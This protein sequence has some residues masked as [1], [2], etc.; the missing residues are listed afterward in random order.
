VFAQ[1]LDGRSLERTYVPLENA[2]AAGRRHAERRDIVFDRDRNTGETT[3][4]F[5]VTDAL[6]KLVGLTGRCFAPSQN[7]IQVRRSSADLTREIE[8]PLDYLARVQRSV[9]NA[10]REVANGKRQSSSC[11]SHGARSVSSP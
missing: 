3:A 1:T 4:E 10:A 5:R 8:G 2:R 7:Q 6:H 11:R 9:A